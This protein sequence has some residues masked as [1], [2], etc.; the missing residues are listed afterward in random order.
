MGLWGFIKSAARWVGEKLGIISEK[1]G[2]SGS[3]TNN[4]SAL[5]IEKMNE[6]L[7]SYSKEYKNHAEKCEME[8]ITITDEYFMHL[9][10]K[11]K[12]KREIQQGVGFR[13][14]E[15]TQRSLHREIR[16]AIIK[17]VERRL[18]LD[19]NECREIIALPASDSKKFKMINF[20]NKVID[21]ANINLS[22]KVA[23]VLNQQA[24]EIDNFLQDYMDEKEQSL[25]NMK[26][27]FADL[28][29]KFMTDGFDAEQIQILPYSKL[30]IINYIEEKVGA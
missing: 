16:G 29:K 22:N 11:M 14:L 1:V 3:V 6:I 20:C 26:H 15:S 8:C 2:N 13:R 23:D 21:E 25:L 10:E 24:E 19:D 17:V 12:Q 9:M 28:E 27:G 7:M 30:Y 4:S 5:S 18:S